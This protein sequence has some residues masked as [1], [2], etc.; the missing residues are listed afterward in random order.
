MPK[1]EQNASYNKSSLTESRN[2][3]VETSFIKIE[4][5]ANSTKS[6]DNF[7]WLSTEVLLKYT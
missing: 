5:V 6:T 2:E 1:R 3:E 4:D 7:K